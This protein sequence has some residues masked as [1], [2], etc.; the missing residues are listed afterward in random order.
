M[1]NKCH[2]YYAIGNIV[3]DKSYV[4]CTACAIVK[5]ENYG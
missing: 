2:L 5:G 4:V 3:C 1:E